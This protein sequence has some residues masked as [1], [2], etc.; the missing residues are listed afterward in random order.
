MKVDILLSRRMHIGLYSIFLVFVYILMLVYALSNFIPFVIDFFKFNGE[1]LI[2]TFK[3]SCLVLA[4]IVFILDIFVKKHDLIFI[5][6]HRSHQKL[7]AQGFLEACIAYIQ[8]FRVEI[9]AVDPLKAKVAFGLG[10]R[11]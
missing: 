8:Q 9:V 6:L 5:G 10:P 4:S 2:G 3:Q 1:H 11:L 7:L